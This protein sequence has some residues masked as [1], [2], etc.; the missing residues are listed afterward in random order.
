M[1]TP[2]RTEEDP[3]DPEPYPEGLLLGLVVHPK[4]RI[5]NKK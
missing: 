1:K 3:D 5:S 4:Y 2:E